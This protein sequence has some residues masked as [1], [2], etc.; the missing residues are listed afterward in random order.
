MSRRPS[1]AIVI[2]IDGLMP[3]MVE[4]FTAEGHMPHLARLMKRGV[5][6]PMLSSP[7]RENV[8]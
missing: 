6:S 2:G 8:Q 5:Y 3:E 7:H 4:K 1:K